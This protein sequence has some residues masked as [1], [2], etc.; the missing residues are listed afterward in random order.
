MKCTNCNYENNG[1]AK[2]CIKCGT[3]LENE[4]KTIVNKKQ[5]NETIIKQDY[6][7]NE[8]NIKTNNNNNK[9]DKSLQIALVMG[10]ISV[11]SRILAINI[12]LSFLGLICPLSGIIGLIFTIKAQKRIKSRQALSTSRNVKKV[13]Y[14]SYFINCIWLIIFAVA[15]V[16]GTA[17]P[18]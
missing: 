10:G 8:L 5:I 17:S 9:S 13:L 11:V 3:S 7:Q 2:F 14:F 4:G 16:F 15:L 1:T 18:S 6:K 12:Y